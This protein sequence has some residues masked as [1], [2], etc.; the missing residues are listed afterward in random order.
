M[1][2]ARKRT[3]KRKTSPKRK[4][5]IVRKAKSSRNLGSKLKKWQKTFSKSSEKFFRRVGC[6]AVAGGILL[7]LLMILLFRWMYTEIQLEPSPEDSS[8]YLSQSRREFVEEL[9]P[10]AQA[11]QRE[12]GILASVSLA[13]AMLE[14]DFGQSQLAS[15]HYNL[16]GVKTDFDDPQGAQYPT[17]EFFEGEWVEIVDTFKVYDS[18]H[19]SMREHAELLTYGT[20]WDSDQYQAVMEGETYQEQAQGLQ[21]SGYATDPAYGDKIINMIEEW[22]LY[23][24]DQPF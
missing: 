19:H 16:Y 5:T 12:Y 10:T 20:S 6:L 21:E 17:L 13:Q 3:T 4:K 23:Q 14:S 18:W 8:T 15:D 7:L 22:G 1:N 11:L 24:Y 9:V 2:L